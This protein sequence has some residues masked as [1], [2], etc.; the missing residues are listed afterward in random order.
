MKS[1]LPITA[2]IEGVTGLAFA[3]MPS[4]FEY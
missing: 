3:I 1:L 4:Y 2:L